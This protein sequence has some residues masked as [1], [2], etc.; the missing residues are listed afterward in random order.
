LALALVNERLADVARDADVGAAVPGMSARVALTAGTALGLLAFLEGAR[1][2]ASSIRAGLTFAVGV[3][4]AL[5]AVQIGRIAR[6]RTRE[7]IES[8]N[9]LVKVLT[10]ALPPPE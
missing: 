1:D 6:D 4:A 8:W 3:I 5:V 10:P 9:T 7:Q 2:P